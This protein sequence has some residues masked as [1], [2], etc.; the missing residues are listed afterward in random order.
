[1]SNARSP[2]SSYVLV[3]YLMNH[4]FVS[5]G[6]KYCIIITTSLM[7]ICG[8]IVYILWYKCVSYDHVLL[9]GHACDE[10]IHISYFRLSEYTQSLPHR[11]MMN[12]KLLTIKP[13]G[14]GRSRVHTKIKR[15]NFKPDHSKRFWGFN[16]YSAKIWWIIT[17]L[18]CRWTC[19]H[20]YPLAI[21][22]SLTISL[23]QIWKF[24]LG[25]EQAHT[26]SIIFLGSLNRLWL[27]YMSINQFNI[28][29]FISIPGRVTNQI[30]C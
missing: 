29:F 8:K 21:V 6:C 18:H 5:R 19:W 22:I 25:N 3:I 28:H 9:F 26:Y 27:N 10:C 1:M 13:Y 16:V 30:D 11:T 24:H 15:L 2:N 20:R 23:A 4:T 7:V 17:L 12:N 14:K